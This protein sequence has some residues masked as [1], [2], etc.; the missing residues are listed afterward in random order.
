MS[1]GGRSSRAYART[2]VRS[3]PIT[4]GACTPRDFRMLAA[5]RGLNVEQASFHYIS[6][7]FS[8]MFPL[9]VLWRLWV[10]GFHAVAGEQAAESFCMAVA[11]PSGAP[12]TSR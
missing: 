12:R 3:W 1:A 8:F 5:K 4:A 7:Y 10:L 2:A 11:K 9:Y 6:S